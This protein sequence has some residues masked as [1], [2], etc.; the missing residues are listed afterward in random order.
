MSGMYDKIEESQGPRAFLIK[1]NED[2]MQSD[3]CIT[4]SQKYLLYLIKSQSEIQIPV[5]LSV[6]KCRN[7][8]TCKTDKNHILPIL[9]YRENSYKLD[10]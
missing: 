6:G 5:E 4:T 2:S 10:K 7:Q 9:S 1:A 3:K 8:S